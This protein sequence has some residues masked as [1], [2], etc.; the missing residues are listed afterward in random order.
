MK[1]GHHEAAMETDF[2]WA[3]VVN[4]K[5]VTHG[6]GIW[7]QAYRPHVS[8]QLFQSTNPLVACYRMPLGRRVVGRIVGTSFGRSALAPVR[9]RPPAG[10]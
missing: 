5:C 3:G 4:V 6:D 9:P 10:D 2:G 1:S 8:E 7:A